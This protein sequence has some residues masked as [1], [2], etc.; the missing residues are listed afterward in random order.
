MLTMFLG[1]TKIKGLEKERERER[2]KP[3]TNYYIKIKRYHTRIK[4]LKRGRND[5][6]ESILSFLPHNEKSM[7]GF[8]GTNNEV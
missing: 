8:L 1:L 3:C 7:T 4:T 2:N 5:L 6:K